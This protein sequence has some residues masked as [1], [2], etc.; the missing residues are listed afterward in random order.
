MCASCVVHGLRSILCSPRIHIHLT[1]WWMRCPPASVA[2]PDASGVSKR[3][4]ET[5][6]G[7]EVMDNVTACHRFKL[8]WRSLTPRLIL[9]DICTSYFVLL[10]D[11]RFDAKSCDHSVRLYA[12]NLN[13]AHQ[14]SVHI[15]NTFGY[16]QALDL[17]V[18]L[19]SCLRD[20]SS[21]ETWL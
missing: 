21:A 3:R 18:E 11:C 15:I 2:V 6:I 4:R 5:M 19:S 13:T 20:R 7:R 16:T 8:M 12:R 1:A 9:A 10:H 17:R 14:I